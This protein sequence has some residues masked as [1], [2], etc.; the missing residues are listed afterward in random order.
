MQRLLNQSESEL[1]DVF[2]AAVALNLKADDSSEG[3]GPY[4]QP[5]VLHA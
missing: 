1:S 3:F 4:R 5:A 2:A